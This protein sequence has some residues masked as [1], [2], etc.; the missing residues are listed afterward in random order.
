MEVMSSLTILC[1][2]SLMVVE[3]GMC[4]VEVGYLG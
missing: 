2:E 3:T 1:S 4:P